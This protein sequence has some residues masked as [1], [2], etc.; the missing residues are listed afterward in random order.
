MRIPIGKIPIQ[1]IIIITIG[2]IIPPNFKPKLNQRTFKN[3][4]IDGLVNAKIKKII[5]K[6]K[7][8]YNT[9]I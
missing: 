5:E 4:N 1:Y 2:A 6:N 8:I 9:L 7:K 3:F